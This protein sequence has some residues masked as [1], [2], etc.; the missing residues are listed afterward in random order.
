MTHGLFPKCRL[1]PRGQAL[2]VSAS[3][4][5]EFA[6]F[7]RSGFKRS[8]EEAADKRDDLRLFDPSDIVAVLESE[9]DY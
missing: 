9:T 1:H 5:D 6:L 3:P 4:A 8:I 2:G 7:S